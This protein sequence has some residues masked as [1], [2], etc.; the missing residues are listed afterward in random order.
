MFSGVDLDWEYPNDEA[1]GNPYSDAD[2]VNF[3]LL[4]A[5]VRKQLDAANRKDVKISIA[6]SAVVEKLQSIDLSTMMNAGM[7]STSIPTR[8]ATQITC[9]TRTPGCLCHWIPRAP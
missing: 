5:E 1:A 3:A 7:A 6:S 9:T 8:F 4:I 2:G